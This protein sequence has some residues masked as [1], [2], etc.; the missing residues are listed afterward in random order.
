MASEVLSTFTTVPYSAITAEDLLRAR[1]EMSDILARSFMLPA[2]LLREERPTMTEAQW[3]ASTDPWA[4]LRALSPGYGDVG[5]VY[6]GR[7]G[8]M[9]YRASDR[10]LRLFACT[11]SALAG[12]TYDEEEYQDH[13][14]A[15]FDWAIH[16][17]SGVR[18]EQKAVLLR[19]I[20]GNPW[21]PVLFR[22]SNGRLLQ[23]TGDTAMAVSGWLTWNDATVPRIAQAIYDEQRFEEMPI[24]ADALEEAGCDNEAILRHCRSEE[25]CQDCSGKGQASDS[26]RFG[27]W[28]AECETCR[29]TG[30]QPLLGPHVRG[31]WVLDLLLGKE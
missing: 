17:T 14:G 13:P 15:A 8:E 3:L 4:M 25:R 27:W 18:S 1:D 7:V 29:G 28:M 24:L 19:D 5:F 9:A 10:K 20:F 22:D 26:D 31:C 30:G 21:R 6:P 2:H 16:Q 23:K 11:C 12:F